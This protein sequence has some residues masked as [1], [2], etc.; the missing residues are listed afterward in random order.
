MFHVEKEVQFEVI[1]QHPYPIVM[2]LAVIK[3]YLIENNYYYL[4]HQI[5]DIIYNI[6]TFPLLAEFLQIH[7]R[8][9][10]ANFC[11]IVIGISN[12]SS[13]K[14][15]AVDAVRAAYREYITNETHFE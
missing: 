13:D 7:G 11:A 5:S 14:R 3:I 12:F 8:E 4:L 1:I 6:E 10:L 9:A 2:V 15:Q